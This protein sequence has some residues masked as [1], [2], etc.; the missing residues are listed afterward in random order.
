MS[1]CSRNVLLAYMRPR[2]VVAHEGWPQRPTGNTVTGDVTLRSVQLVEF[3]GILALH[4]LAFDVLGR[5]Q[6]RDKEL[7]G[8]PRAPNIEQQKLVPQEEDENDGA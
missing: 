7:A 2:F 6:A 5:R 3:T 8:R 4:T 1:V